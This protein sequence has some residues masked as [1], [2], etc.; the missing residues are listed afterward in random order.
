MS[1]RRSQSVQKSQKWQYVRPNALDGLDGL[2]TTLPDSKFLINSTAVFYEWDDYAALRSCNIILLRISAQLDLI[3]DFFHLDATYNRT[4]CSTC[5]VIQSFDRAQL[6]RQIVTLKKW[7]RQKEPIG[8]GASGTIWL[9]HDEDGKESRV[10]K[11]MIKVTPTSTLQI[12]HKRELHALGCLSKASSKNL[13]ECCWRLVIEQHQHLFIHFYGRFENDKYIFLAME[14][15]ELG[16]LEKFITPQ[17][18]EK[19]SKVKALSQ[20]SALLSICG[21]YTYLSLVESA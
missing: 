5:E 20:A 15:F 11:E 6:K 17:M 3:S 8:F 16:D 12:D 21:K 4:T 13:Y 19:D 10:V 9:E 1:R 2:L 7:K 18:T 14:Y